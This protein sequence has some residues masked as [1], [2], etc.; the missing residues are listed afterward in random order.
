MTAKATIDIPVIPPLDPARFV[1]VDLYSQE[2]KADPSPWFLQ[3]ADKPPFY[4]MIHGRPNAV[5]CR[6]EQV[7]WALSDYDSISAVPQP[8]WGADYLDWFNGLPIVIE[9]DPPEHTRLRRL[10]QPAFTPRRVSQFQEGIN[11]LVDEMIEMVAAKGEFDMPTEFAQ[12]LVAR[13]LLGTFFQF[14][15]EDWPIFINFSHALEL[16]ATVPP[17]APKPQAYLDAYNAVYKYCE[18]IIEQRRREPKDDLV[19]NIIAA[20]EGGTITTEEL[21]AT[22]IVLF[23]GGLGTVSGTIGLCMLRLCRHPDQLKLLQDDPT[24][25]QPA[26][27]ECLRIDSLGNFRHRYVVKDCVVDGVP[28]YRGM[29]VHCSM[30]AS[31]YDPEFYPDPGKFDIKRNPRDIST[32]GHATH[33]CVGQGLARPAVRESISRLVKRFPKIRLSDP[34]ETIV[35]GG[36]ATERMPLNI[37]L[38]VD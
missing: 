15:M 34:N 22:L 30:G 2:I 38:R 4:V 25:L 36:M 7:K 3:W 1:D 33:F 37:R 16:V 31:N 12:P 13:L 35:Y 18:G 14:P 9:F 5:L 11:Q 20:E 21:F 24:L 29:I 10:M 19:G 27:E 23:T 32:F 17:G 28:L 6:H 8:G 26:I